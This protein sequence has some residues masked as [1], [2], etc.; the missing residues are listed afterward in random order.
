MP[1][2]E[3]VDLLNKRAGADVHM[4]MN[5]GMFHIDGAPV[6]LLVQDGMEWFPLN[7]DSGKRGN[8]FLLPNGVFGQDKQGAF[9][10]VTTERA[11]DI[12]W[13]EATQSGPMLL[14]D[15]RPHP[16]FNESSSN[17]NIRN[18]V[19]IRPDGSVVFGLSTDPITFYAFASAFALKGCHQALYL[20]GAI[21]RMQILG[22]EASENGGEFSVMIGVIDSSQ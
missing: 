5:G 8:F 19:G 15:G 2:E 3:G 20:D 10:V 16:S 22:A 12:V 13:Q 7:R 18:G 17:K 9:R 14:I 11:A 4:A 21:S 1:F 6:G